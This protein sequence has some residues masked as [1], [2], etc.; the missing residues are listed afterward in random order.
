MLG[1]KKQVRWA[2]KP[3][4][5]PGYVAGLHFYW[6]L[7]YYID[8]WLSRWLAGQAVGWLGG[9]IFNLVGGWVGGACLLWLD[10]F[11]VGGYWVAM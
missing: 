7:D 11:E 6:P 5:P 1:A 2:P 10:G 3:P 9:W 8:D 4:R